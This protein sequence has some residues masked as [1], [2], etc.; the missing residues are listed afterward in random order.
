MGVFGDIWD[1]T[2][3]NALPAAA[4][5]ATGGAS[6]LIGYGAS[7]A[8]DAAA[9]GETP[10][11]QAAGFAA[12]GVG[13][14]TGSAAGEVTKNLTVPDKS[15][16]DGQVSQWVPPY[17]YWGGD[18]DAATNYSGMALSRLGGSDK[19]AGWAVDQAQQ[20]RTPMARENQKLSD[21]ESVSRGYYQN[22]ALDL[23]AQAAMGNAPSEA[24]YMMQG[25][26][27]RAVSGQKSMAAGARGSGAIAL[28]QGNAQANQANLQNQTFQQAGQLRAQEMANARNSFGQLAGQQREQD[29]NRLGQGNQMSQFN[30]GLNDQYK[31]GMLQQGQG[32]GNQALGWYQAGMQPYNQQAALDAAHLGAET[33]THNQTNALNAGIRQAGQDRKD[34]YNRALIGLA[35]TA[36]GAGGGMMGAYMGKPTGG[37]YPP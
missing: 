30:A 31:M 18:P 8:V 33:D 12:G 34:A 14:L 17:E 3:D 26:L 28:A 36:I 11:G 20:D 19:T 1:W 22:G 16:G 35:G 32:Y 23:A 37:G 24:A 9:G 10:L 27:D 6:G 2:K 4:A 29:Q 5:V 21:N 7:Q 25:G 13:G 15:G